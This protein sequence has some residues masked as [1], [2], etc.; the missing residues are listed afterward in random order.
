MKQFLFFLFFCPLF[1]HPQTSGKSFSLDGTIKGVANGTT[2]YILNE[3]I[4]PDTL[5]KAKVLNNKFVLKGSVP[6]SA[7][8]YIGFGDNPKRYYL[9]VD[10]TPMVFTGDF[11]ALDKAIVTGSPVHSEF[12]KMTDAFDPLLSKLN[13]LG[14]SYNS[15]ADAK[16]RDS[17]FTQIRAVIENID[18]NVETYVNSKQG[19]DVT[20]LILL[21]TS[22]LSQ[23]YQKLG[24]RFTALTPSV[25]KSFYGRILR[26]IIE[27]AMIGNVGTEAIDFTQAD[28]SGNPVTLS[29][30]RGK[31]VLV[32]FWASWCGPCRYENPNVVAAFNEYK[33]KNFTILGVSLDKRKEPWLQAIKDDGLTWTHVSD[34]KFWNNEVAMLYK[35]SSIPQNILID[36]SGKI[37]AKNL[38]GEELQSKL[39]E[40]LQ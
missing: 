2:V 7:L 33:G 17:L 13:Q 8:Y 31:Y 35:I 37:V 3:E 9:Y 10:N 39:K 1:A 26:E 29:S 19:S 21:M 32:D 20:A 25:Q 30:F 24:Q 23:D 22:N 14:T 11:N 28:T 6:E 4:G 34:L 18:A 5:A 40:L 36:P 38:R 15:T 16:K 27:K 12:I